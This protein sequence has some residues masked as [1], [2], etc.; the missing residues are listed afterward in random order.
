MKYL[1]YRHDWE[2]MDSNV[3]KGQKL[4]QSKAF[5]RNVVRK[6]DFIETIE[7]ELLLTIFTIGLSIL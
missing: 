5:P 1:A 6:D 2:V 7:V 4:C 3:T